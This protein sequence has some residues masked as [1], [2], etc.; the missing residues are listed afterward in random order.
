MYVI[1]HMYVGPSQIQRITDDGVRFKQ[2]Y[3]VTNFPYIAIIDPR[4]GSNV[5][6]LVLSPG[7][8]A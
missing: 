6:T 1:M 2:L 5:V 3:H 8:S 7:Y 4:T